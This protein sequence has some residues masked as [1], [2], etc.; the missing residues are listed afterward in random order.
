MNLDALDMFV[1]TVS[2]LVS[3]EAMIGVIAIAL[4]YWNRFNSW[5]ETEAKYGK[6]R[7]P[8][9]FTTWARFVTYATLYTLSMELIYLLLLSSPNLI[10]FLGQHIGESPGIPESLNAG[11][12]N[13]PLWV[14]VFLIGFYPHLPGLRQMEERYRCWFHIR[15]FIPAEAK[16]LVQH[17]VANPAF[18]KP[19]E[20]TTRK[21]IRN[22][23]E[24]MPDDWGR[25][26]ADNRLSSKWFRLVYLREK[27]EEWRAQPQIE[28]FVGHCEEEYKLF[29]DQFKQLNLDVSTYIARSHGINGAPGG[30]TRDD[31]LE[32]LKRNIMWQI[33]KLLGRAY[34][35][36]ACG[37]LSTERVHNRRMAKLNF[38]GLYPT[39][40]PGIP[41]LLDIV[42]KNATIVFMIAAV[43]SMSYI[44]YRQIHD[45]RPLQLALGLVYA[46]IALLMIGLCIFS[47]VIVYRVLTRK[48]RFE[49]EN[50]GEALLI[51]PFVHQC[52]G[53]VTGYLCGL[54]VI[55]PY[56]ATGS[57]EG[58]WN[59]LGRSLPWPLIPAITAG[60]VVYYLADLTARRSRIKDSIVQGVITGAV[61]IIACLW[62]FDGTPGNLPSYVYTFTTCLCI[63][64]AIGYFFPLAYHQRVASIYHGAERRQTPRIAIVAPSALRSEEGIVSC[65]AVNISAGGAR[66]NADCNV[67]LGDPIQFELPGVGSLQGEVIRKSD[68]ETVVRFQNNQTHEALRHYIG[69]I[70]W[71]TG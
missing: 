47:A 39:Y 20:E 41:I 57:K 21:V 70:A 10:A 27:F 40:E 16:A 28:R 13:F 61:G 4:F 1:N 32:Q 55:F 34:E 18:F 51:G 6:A 29:Q 7:P 69:D 17:L 31:S 46:V 71:A 25:Q 60:F 33:E 37:V 44:G 66:L 53:F 15:A 19:D 38:F 64:G 8:R 26:L 50:N 24:G 59:S 23:G 12:A 68:R 5:T 49:T 67:D 3:L 58:I 22:Y 52:I 42:L 48:S 62:A 9:Q 2:G 56:I 45:G 36:V 43:T 11:D 65:E 54:L 30:P 14:M 35:F 63:G